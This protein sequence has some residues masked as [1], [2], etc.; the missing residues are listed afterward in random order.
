VQDGIRSVVT[1]AL[2]DSSPV[3][4]A[5][6]AFA[7]GSVYLSNVWYD[8]PYRLSLSADARS[9]LLSALAADISRQ[10][11]ADRYFP[12]KE[13][14]GV[15][16]F[17][18]TGEA[19]IKSY[20]YHLGNASVYITDDFTDTLTFLENNGLSG[21]LAFTGEIESITLQKYD[22]YGGINGRK[23]PLSNFF[24]GYRGTSLD[25]FMVQVDFGAKQPVTDE[26]RIAGLLPRLRSTYSMTREGYLAAIKLKG[27]EYYIYKYLPGKID[28]TK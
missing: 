6:K 8:K 25:D 26:T 24:I 17:T 1:G 11:A 16:F 28:L 18:S 20:S 22:P 14:L 13:A 10:T 9:A 15:L 12:Q 5:S 3:N 4:W 23:K 21:C 2:A 7:S 19:D 27:S